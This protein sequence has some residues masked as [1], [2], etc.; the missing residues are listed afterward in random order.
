MA[1]DLW[2]LCWLFWVLRYQC[3][4]PLHFFFRWKSVIYCKLSLSIWSHRSSCISTCSLWQRIDFFLGKSKLGNFFKF[5][6]SS[7]S[8][9]QHERH[10]RSAQKF[11]RKCEPFPNDGSLPCCRVCLCS[12]LFFFALEAN[13]QRKL[14]LPCSVLHDESFFFS[15]PHKHDDFRTLCSIKQ[16]NCEY[17]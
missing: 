3:W 9:Y 6:D 15:L 10:H 14:T 16:P 5:D 13:T 4:I 17:L 11:P 12:F 2:M 8:S 1:H 7:E